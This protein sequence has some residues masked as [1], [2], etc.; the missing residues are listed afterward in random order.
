MYSLLPEQSQLLFERDIIELLY[1]EPKHEL[2]LNHF[3]K[4]Y[5]KRF[6]KI[7]KISDFGVSKLMHLV[8][9]LTKGFIEVFIAFLLFIF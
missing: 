7:L 4:T 2:L 3:A 8:D 5:T 6:G 9:K 1:A